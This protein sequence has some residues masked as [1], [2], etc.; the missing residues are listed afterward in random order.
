MGEPLLELSG[1]QYQRYIE[2]YN[3]P[4]ASELYK[5]FSSDKTPTALEYF[6]NTIQDKKYTDGEFVKVDNDEEKYTKMFNEENELINSNRK[7]KITMIRRIDSK[8]KEIAKKLMFLEYPELL[9]VKNQRE[10]Y[11]NEFGENPP[12]I[13]APTQDELNTAKEQRNEILENAVN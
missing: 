6:A 7:F 10:A 3:N 1:K 11:E 8:Y 2:L 12:M 5:K 4:M 9:A 13:T